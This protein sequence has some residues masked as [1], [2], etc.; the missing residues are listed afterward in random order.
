M[1]YWFHRNPLKATTAVGFNLQ[2]IA[3]NSDAVQIC[4]ELKQN[5]EKLIELFTDANNSVSSVETTLHNYLSLLM[6][7]VQALDNRGGDYSKLRHSLRFKWTQTMLGNVPIVQQDALFE[8]ISICEE[9]AIWLMKH[10][11]AIAGKDEPKMEEAKEVHTS[12]RKASG[13]FSALTVHIDNLLEKPSPGSD[14]DNR[15]A[16]AYIQQLT[17]ARAIELKHNAALISGLANEASKT[18]L[19]AASS[20][21]ALDATKFGKW[22]KYFQLKSVF[23]EAYAYCYL[24]EN[25]LSLDKCGEAIRALQEAEKCLATAKELCKEYEKAKGVGST[26]KISENLFFRS[27]SPLIK[28][29]KEKCEREN[30]M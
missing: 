21:K 27:L 8:L 1:A 18:F 25:L 10:A 17:I 14:M 5:R 19:A 26:A 6:G 11:S 15:V 16:N 12:L 3:V 13:V 22:L 9:Y 24:G 20:I 29:T 28:R 7:F 23:Y 4:S 2:M 30:G